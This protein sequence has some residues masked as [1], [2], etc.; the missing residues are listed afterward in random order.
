MSLNDFQ[1]IEFGLALFIDN[2]E[3]YIRIPVDNTV[4]ESLVDMRKEFYTQYDTGEEE[5]EIF[6]PS[7]KYA[8]TERLRVN[9][10][11]DY[12]KSIRGLYQNTNISIVSKDLGD[13]AEKIGYY[14]AVFYSN[15]GNRELA[16][17]RSS[18]FKGLLK[19]KNKLV[20]LFDDTLK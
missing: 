12:L 7:E 18:Q 10:N 2:E 13:V 6:L 5:P 1:N 11:E 8:S 3:S 16:I 9:L 19:K 20:R 15:H 14:F 4:K 17:K